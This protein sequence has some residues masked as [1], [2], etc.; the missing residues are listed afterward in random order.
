MELKKIKGRGGRGCGGV[1]VH[2]E[3]NQLESEWYVFSFGSASSSHSWEISV[4]FPG[5][6]KQPLLFICQ[7]VVM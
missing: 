2:V 5:K 1:G 6:D 3:T 4:A 7:P